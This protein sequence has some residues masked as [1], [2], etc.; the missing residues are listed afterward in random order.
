MKKLRWPICGVQ[1]FLCF[2]VFL[3]P[4]FKLDLCAVQDN[5]LD[6]E[7]RELLPKQDPRALETA[8]EEGLRKRM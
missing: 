7:L 8:S 5:F 6:Q 4:L 1:P 2:L 3:Q